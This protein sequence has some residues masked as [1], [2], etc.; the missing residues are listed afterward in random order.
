[1]RRNVCLG[2]FGTNSD[3]SVRFFDTDF[4]IG[5]DVSAIEGLFSV[6]FFIEKS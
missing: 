4:L 6:G 5:S 3:I 1:M 2:A